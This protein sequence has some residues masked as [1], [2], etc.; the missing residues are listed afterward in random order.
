MIIRLYWRKLAH[1]LPLQK[2][3]S[4]KEKKAMIVQV[5][6]MLIADADYVRSR[7]NKMVSF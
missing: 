2:V 5:T 6:M 3:K 7:K 4:I 1:S